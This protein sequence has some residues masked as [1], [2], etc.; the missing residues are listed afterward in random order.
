MDDVVKHEDFAT[1]S[2]GRILGRVKESV[3]RS[4]GVSPST[5][6]IKKISFVAVRDGKKVVGFNYE[7]AVKLFYNLSALMHFRHESIA[8]PRA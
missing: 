4:S 5:L 7:V 1:L 2:S 6:D 3:R 8:P